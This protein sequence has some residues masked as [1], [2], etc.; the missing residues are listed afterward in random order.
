MTSRKFT[1]SNHPNHAARSAHIKGERQF[2]TYDTSHIRPKK[3]K[4]P[5]IFG[6]VLA[7]VILGLA[8]WG[9]NM[10]LNTINKGSLADGVEVQITIP[11]GTG[12]KAIG[13]LLQDNGVIASANEFVNRVGELGADSDL[14][15]GTY[16][17]KGGMTLDQV[18]AVLRL[19]P[20]STY[21]TFTIPEGFTLQQTAQRVEDSYGGKVTADD[22]LACANNA[23]DYEADF[24]FVKG[25]YNNSLEGFLF[26][27]TYTVDPNATADD[28]VRMMLTQFQT[29]TASLDYTFAQGKNLS[30]YQVLIIASMIEREA[31][32]D[33]ER[34]TISSVIYN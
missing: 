24:P 17:F 31:M 4:V 26:P 27:K 7:A 6:I 20:E 2:K 25:A 32:L 23:S 9:G 30:A 28:V 29:E 34:P 16:N 12:A 14:K 19:G 8:I 10:L 11:D 15:P 3:S 13:T 1:Y 22:F 33:E 5:L 18:I 21:D